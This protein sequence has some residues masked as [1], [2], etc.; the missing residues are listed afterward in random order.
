VSRL[1]DEQ[2]ERYSR[3]LILP[4]LGGKSQRRLLDARAVVI[5]AGGLGSPIIQYLAAAGVGHLDIIDSDVV[6]LSNLQRQIIH[7]GSEIG[8]PK[9]ESA[10]RFARRLN[11]D[12]E[13]QAKVLRLDASNATELLRHAD[14]VLEG[15]DNFPTR[16]LVN[17]ACYLLRKPLVSG[18]ILRFEGQVTVFPNDGGADSPCYR[19]L[20]PEMPPPGAIPTCQEAGVLGS[21]AGTIGTLQAT[22]A[23]KVLLGIGESL[24]GRLLIHDGLAGTFRTIRL[25]RDPDCAL[26]GD[27]PTIRE[28]RLEAEAG[29]SRG[30]NP[31]P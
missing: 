7:G 26:C 24:A 13:A 3:Q 12:C 25:H 4:G 15:S 19:C 5:G 9:A 20:F 21:L 14:I 23:I 18:A 16:F 2:M 31:P 22:E 6:E 30:S 11:P 17:D 10:A 8:M 27:H 29:C 28:L 1:T